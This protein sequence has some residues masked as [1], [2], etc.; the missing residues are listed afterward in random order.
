VQNKLHFATTGKTAA[1]IIHQRADSAKPNMGLTVW[2]NAPDG[3]I[4]ESDI[5]IAKNYLNEE[6]LDH[7]NRVVTMYL[8]FAE[9]QAERGIMMYMKD[10]A[11]KLDAFLKFN[12]REILTDAGKISQEVAQ[13]LAMKEYEIYKKEQ[14]KLYESDFDREVKKI[15]NKSKKISQS[16][17]EK[18]KKKDD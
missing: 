5:V 16:D 9:M 11:S 10:W 17:F 7:L 8:D 13:A 14:D 1:E 4:R 2:K 6:E 3:A 12:E 15:F 18:G